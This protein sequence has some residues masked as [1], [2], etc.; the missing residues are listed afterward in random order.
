MTTR[1]VSQNTEENPIAGLPV[2]GDV[3]EGKYRIERELGSGGMGVVFEVTHLLLTPHRFAIKWLVPPGDD[4]DTARRFVR[5]ANI[6]RRIRHPHVV[7]LYDICMGPSGCFQVMELLEGET[8]AARLHR[9]GR[10]AIDEA[11]QIFLPSLSAIT[12]AHAAGV[13]HRDLKPDNI[14]LCRT[15]RPPEV[16]PKVLDFGVSRAAPL[17]G[18]M[19]T[20]ATRKGTVVGTPAYMAP[21]QLRGLPVDERTDIY[22]LGVSLYEALCGQRPFIALTYPELAAKI[23]TATPVPLYERVPGLPLALSQ[24]VARAMERE[25][26]ARYANVDALASALLPY[27]ERSVPA[28]VPQP[29]AAKRGRPLLVAAA[30]AAA[31]GGVLWLM[32]R[33]PRA[34]DVAPSTSAPSVA[35]PIIRDEPARGAAEAP[36]DAPPTPGQPNAERVLPNDLAPSRDVDVRGA[37][38]PTTAGASPNSKPSAARPRRAG[39]T[40]GAS[41]SKAS[42]IPTATAPKP[43]KSTSANKDTPTGPA[44]SASDGASKPA[45]PTPQAASTSSAHGAPSSRDRKSQRRDSPPS[46][47]DEADLPRH[48]RPSPGEV[49]GLS[50]GEF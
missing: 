12:A 48:D 8:L 17:P 13:I 1:R 14:F 11:C 20:T 6:A 7:E 30:L 24:I 23:L 38:T 34:T 26:S 33:A 42:A 50:V 47:A 37:E 21:E 4:G 29:S 25:P 36:G 15:E 2:A 39:A 3:L 43:A 44:K 40:N 31:I 32:P 28:A 49:P 41:T 46:A 22:S 45:K 19:D 10:L 18:M 16:K 35:T 5:E 27:A 9:D